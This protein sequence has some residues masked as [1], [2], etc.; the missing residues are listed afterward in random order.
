MTTIAFANRIDQDD[1]VYSLSQ[2]RSALSASIYGN[3]RLRQMLA[4][5]GFKETLDVYSNG[6]V[7]RLSVEAE[8]YV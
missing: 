3:M 8:S 7:L 6:T 5:S 1:P 4:V 2:V